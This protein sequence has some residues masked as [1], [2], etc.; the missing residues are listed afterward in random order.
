[1]PDAFQPVA[2][3]AQLGVKLRLQVRVRGGLILR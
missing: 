3:A 2:T 1:V